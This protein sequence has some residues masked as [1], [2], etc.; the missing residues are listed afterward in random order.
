M[1][2]LKLLRFSGLLPGRAMALDRALQSL[3]KR[4]PDRPGFARGLV[5][6]GAGLALVS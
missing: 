2:D 5:S 3:S 1:A 6:S 4:N